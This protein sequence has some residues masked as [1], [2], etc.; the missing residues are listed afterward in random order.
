MN[1]LLAT[2]AVLRAAV[3]SGARF[4]TSA[5]V[6]GVARKGNA[7]H[8]QTT[9]GDIRAGQ[10]LIAAGAWSADVAAMLDVSLP[11]RRT[12]LQMIVTEPLPKLT[13]M[14]IAHVTDRLT[15]KQARA[16][17]AI[18]GGGWRAEPDALTGCNRVRVDGLRG[19]LIAAKRAIP[20]LRTA[21]V[22]RSW[23]AIS[24]TPAM[25]PLLGKLPGIPGCYVAVT[26]N[27]MTL[28][29]VLGQIFADLLQGRICAYDINR[30]DPSHG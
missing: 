26:L 12:A 17:N 22:I 19:N 4:H 21:Q 16:G 1:P 28:G 24:G 20:S 23:T 11:V 25:G 6:I 2:N 15:I 27:G 18:I 29:P 5:S 7:F 3:S 9:Q 10:I 8:V 30:F 14:L 13:D